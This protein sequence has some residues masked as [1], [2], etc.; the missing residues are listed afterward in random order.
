MYQNQKQ[1]PLLLLELE[2]L[3][4]DFNF[5]DQS[6][7]EPFLLQKDRNLQKQ[8]LKLVTKFFDP[9]STYIAATWVGSSCLCLCTSVHYKPTDSHSYLLY[10]SSHPLH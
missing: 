10:S 6:T 4:G 9:V 7:T 1:Q 8:V 5:E 2:V 3:L